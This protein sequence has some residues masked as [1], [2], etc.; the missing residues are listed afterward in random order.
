MNVIFHTTTAIGV[1][2]LLTDTTRIDQSNTSK[3]VFWTS[4]LA[5]TVGLISHGVL[6]YIPHCYPVNSKFDAISGLVVILTTTW[7]T[8]KKYRLIMGVSFLGCIFPDLVDLS[9]GIV[10]KQLGLSLPIINKIFPWHLHDYSGSIYNNN[11]NNSTLN[12]MLLLLTICIVCWCRWTDVKII[13][14]KG[15]RPE[16]MAQAS[17][18]GK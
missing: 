5:F 17:R 4:I 18:P 16:I 14:K 6:D 2:V 13:F 9:P 8:N 1:A 3:N 11:C 7:L 15:A 10:N 12:H